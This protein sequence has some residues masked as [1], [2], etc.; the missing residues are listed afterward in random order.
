MP[1]DFP[2]D[3]QGHLPKTYSECGGFFQF[4]SS[5]PLTLAERQLDLLNKQA[6]LLKELKVENEILLEAL[7]ESNFQETTAV[8]LLSWNAVFLHTL[9]D[10][11]KDN[12]MF[13][14]LQKKARQLLKR[15]MLDMK[16]RANRKPKASRVQ[17][18]T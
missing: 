1:N 5:K 8:E 2:K 15:D 18:S 12:P 9:L 16:I 3:A 14:E 4:I 17:K 6:A 10:E 11:I 7:E 13:L